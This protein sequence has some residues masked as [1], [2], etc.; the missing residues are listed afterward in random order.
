MTSNASNREKPHR[1][2][3]Q[4]PRDPKV[5]SKTIRDAIAGGSSPNTTF[6]ELDPVEPEMLNPHL[7]RGRVDKHDGPWA[8]AETLLHR[9]LRL[10]EYG[11]AEFLIDSGAKIDKRNQLG[12]TPLHE[13]VLSRSWQA[14]GLLIKRGADVEI[15][16]IENDVVWYKG[17]EAVSSEGDLTLMHLALYNS[18]VD[19]LRLLLAQGADINHKA[20]GIW[21][22]LDLSLLSEDRRAVG[23]FLTQGLKLRKETFTFAD[24]KESKRLS[25]ELQSYV[26]SR[27]MV[28]PADLWDSYREALSRLHFCK[29]AVDVEDEEDPPT[30]DGIV[31]VFSDHLE[32]LAGI[33]RN[34]RERCDDCSIF[35]E[36]LS[37]FYEQ[38]PMSHSFNYRLKPTRQALLSTAD[39]DSWPCDLCA[40]I[41]DS[42]DSKEAKIRHYK[43]ASDDWRPSGGPFDISVSMV[44]SFEAGVTI[45]TL[46]GS[47]DTS[48]PHQTSHSDTLSIHGNFGW[49]DIST[50]PPSYEPDNRL[51]GTGS[52]R[53]F[54]TAT[55]WLKRCQEHQPCQEAVAKKTIGVRR[56]RLLDVGDDSEPPRLVEYP[57]DGAAYVALSSCWESNAT[58]TLMTTSTNIEQHNKS[59]DLKALPATLQ[60]AFTVTRRLGF[61]YIWVDVLC[62]VQDSPGIW[63]ERTSHMHY[64]YDNAALTI[65][66]LGESRASESLFTPRLSRS[67]SPVP[68]IIWQPKC[69]RPKH[70]EGVI[71]RFALERGEYVKD[72]EFEGPVSNRAWGLQ[73][74]LFSSRLLHFGNGMLHWECLCGY[75]NEILSSSCDDAREVIDSRIKRKAALKGVLA[76]RELNQDTKSFTALE[77]WQAQLEDFTQRYVSKA[78]DRLPA[79]WAV[80]MH[81]KDY[82]EDEFSCGL[83]KGKNFLG[84]LCWAAKIPQAEKSALPSWTWV[85]NSQPITFACFDTSGRQRES[86]PLTSLISFDGVMEQNTFAVA[87]SLTL[88]GPLYAFEERPKNWAFENKYLDFGRQEAAW[89]AEGDI[90]PSVFDGVDV[91]GCYILEILGIKGTTGPDKLVEPWQW[92]GGRAAKKVALLLEKV[93]AEGMVFRRAGILTMELVGGKFEAE[94]FLEQMDKPI[95]TLV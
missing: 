93:G 88:Q 29:W 76:G 32:T 58:N 20:E 26:T 48:G 80:P 51:L 25:K 67:L 70:S 90:F 23:F 13:A 1:K 66:N 34:T 17:G 85:S 91:T 92:K 79:F 45:R 83:W 81:M 54:A 42:L 35:A 22:Y 8:Q 16:T 15:L 10:H 72:R 74:E 73:E 94:P 78:S 12:R 71:H 19:M 46:Q 40:L 77:N 86:G 6:T 24:P 56:P 55:D 60:E 52:Q 65:S 21:S 64:I 38:N 84:S 27:R 37:F 18:D 36:E 47:C 68:L 50:L 39:R 75:K 69:R 33:G 62:M 2:I 41:A 57:E 7:I 4:W 63:V 43:K 31:A 44:D 49:F 14:V 9:A 30:A 5:F 82:L 61:K 53:A 11:L 89:D 28:P 3:T 95:I 59:I 87:G